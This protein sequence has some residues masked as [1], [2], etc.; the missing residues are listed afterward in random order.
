MKDLMKYIRE[1]RNLSKRDI[2]EELMSEYTYTKIEK[3]IEVAELSMLN[4]TLERMNVTFNEFAYLY[5]HSKS[6]QDFF[7]D[8]N[9]SLSVG[10]VRIDD[11]MSQHPYL[12]EFHKNILYCLAT[13]YEGDLESRNTYKEIIWNELTERENLLPNDIVLLS[14]IFYVFEGEQ[15]DYILKEIEDKMFMWEDYREISNVISFFYFNL[16]TLHEFVFRD[17]ELAK[18]TYQKSIDK[19]IQHQTPSSAAQAMIH[20]GKLTQDE[21][22]IQKGRVILSVFNPQLLEL[23]EKI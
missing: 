4:D 15:R 7:E 9:S 1:S 11:F 23:I 13:L 6:F 20:L 17:K 12:T 14:Y 18:L 21:A 8:L 19:G 2:Y 5:S 16:G 22:L 10:P 3:D